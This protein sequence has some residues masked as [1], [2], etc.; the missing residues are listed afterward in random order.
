MIL[1]IFGT[2]KVKKKLE[3]LSFTYKLIFSDILAFRKLRKS[4]MFVWA[5]VF[6]RWKVAQKLKQ[7]RPKH[8]HI[9]T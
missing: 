5:Y 6:S 3:K 4:S 9:S 7:T 1:L 8:M 2:Q